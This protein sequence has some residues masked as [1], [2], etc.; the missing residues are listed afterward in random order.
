MTDNILVAEISGKR[1]GS[2][3]QRPTERYKTKH[4]M[5]IISNNSEGYE[6]D[7]PIVD[8]PDDYRDWYI[9]NIK[10][11]DN[12]WYAP[13]NRSYAIKYARDNGYRYLVQLDDN[14]MLLELGLWYDGGSTG[15]RYRQQFW[16]R[17][18]QE[19]RIKEILDDYIE[20]LKTVLENTNAGM[21]GCQLAGTA[22]PEWRFLREGYCY[23]LFML[24]VERVPDVFQ[25]DFE[26][27]IEFRL[28]LKQMGVPVVQIPLLRYAKM[29]QQQNKDEDLSGCRAEYAK[30]GLKRGEHM[31]KLYS[32]IYRCTMTNK[33]R[34]VMAKPV[35]EAIYFKHIIKPFKVGVV[36]S[37]MDAIKNAVRGI[38]EKY[39]SHKPDKTIR[40]VKKVKIA[41]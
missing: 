25:G 9:A 24:D 20:V 2:E 7:L 18:G 26:D 22:I 12:A 11:S 30:A 13:M 16:S 10:N 27:D 38:I 36:V 39:A 23:S 40:K 29:G 41:E 3:V 19:E 17:P 35:E 14:I 5:V 6:T 15:K 31:G 32:D 37:D 34:T 33:T 4:P 1:P 28:K 8:V 21:A